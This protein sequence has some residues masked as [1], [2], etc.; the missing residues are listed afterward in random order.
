V[1]RSDLPASWTLDKTKTL[2][3]DEDLPMRVCFSECPLLLSGE[4]VGSLVS[5]YATVEA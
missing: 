5:G 2:A 4:Q 1:L 3:R